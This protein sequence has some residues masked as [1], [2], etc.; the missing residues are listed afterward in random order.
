VSER[1]LKRLVGALAAVVV[2]WGVA[3]LVSR[4][5]DDRAGVG[6]EI[7]AFFEGVDSSSVTGARI[8]RPR[9]TIALELEGGV[10]R[11]NGFASDSGSIARFLATLADAE[12]T[13]MVATN[14]ANHE[15]MGVSAD[16]ARALVL[17]VGGATRRLLFGKEGPRVATIYA[18]A[19]DRDEVYL[20][21]GGLW[22]H[23]N[24][25]LD[26]WRNRRL[27]AIDT[28]RVRRISV[29]RDGDRFTL[30]RADTIWTFE[31]GSPVRAAQVRSLLNELG[32]GL[33]ASRF[34]GDS[35]SLAARPPGGST[36][37]YAET[38]E[39]LAE[40]T[41]SARDEE[42]TNDRW[43]MVAGD[44]VRYRLPGFRVDMIVPTR[45]SL[46]P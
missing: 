10:W 30:V 44:S 12:V 35:E 16:S 20:V 43:G 13:E 7:A 45:A 27:L 11:V 18:R 6:E 21:S 24:R 19:P 17:E 29:D 46:A 40:V 37:A 5:G 9:D 26:D 15:R 3:T 25:Q 31:D 8:E 34:V 4:A 2:L 36:I 22:S 1:T 28:A 23:L 14:P 39:V 32:G 33:I 42:G 41:V 38:G